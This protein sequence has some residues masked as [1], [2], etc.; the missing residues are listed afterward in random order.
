MDKPREWD[1]WDVDEDYELEGEEV[2]A[3][4]GVEVIENGPL[5]ASVRVERRWRSSS[6]AQT[7]RLLRRLQAPRR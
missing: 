2:G 6:I 7:Y 3:V 1:A 4:E 5:R